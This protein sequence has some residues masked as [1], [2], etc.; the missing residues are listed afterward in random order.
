MSEIENFNMIKPGNAFGRAGP[1]VSGQLVA[2]LNRPEHGVERCLDGNQ[3]TNT[4]QTVDSAVALQNASFTGIQWMLE[5]KSNGC[6]RLLNQGDPGCG[7]TGHGDI[8]EL[9]SLT[10]DPEEDDPHGDW[11][12][13]AIGNTSDVALRPVRGAWLTTMAEGDGV[14]LSKHSETAI[15]NARWIILG[16]HFG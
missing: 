14:V 1:F 4:V 9:Q 6:W 3:Y 2:L 8:V 10:D 7:L 5:A 16:N 15:P 13:Y 11:L 12:I